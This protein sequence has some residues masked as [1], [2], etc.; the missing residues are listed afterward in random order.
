[1][2]L[3][4]YNLKVKPFEITPNPS[5]FWLGEKHKEGW[6]ALEYGIRENKG[7]LLLTGDIGTGKTVLIN[8]LIKSTKVSTVIAKIPDPDLESLDFFNILSEEFQ[9]NKQFDSKGNFLI[10]FKNFLYEVYG[11][12][13]KVLLII[14]EAQR[15]N[16]ELLEQIRALSN[17]EMDDKK[18]INIFFCRTK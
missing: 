14:D 13:R 17:I 4:H 6:A 7:F 18:L 10:E 16:S 15:L 8:Y 3:A 12:D 2:Y 9:M 1:M 11:S 5:F